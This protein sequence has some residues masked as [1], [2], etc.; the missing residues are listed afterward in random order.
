MCERAARS[1]H[2]EPCPTSPTYSSANITCM[3]VCADEYWRGRFSRLHLP[4]LYS[5]SP[6]GSFGADTERFV[7]CHVCLCVRARVC[8]CLYALCERVSGC[9]HYSCSFVC[10]FAGADGT[11][12]SAL[13]AESHQAQLISPDGNDDAA[14]AMIVDLL[15]ANS[16]LGGAIN[17][18][19]L[20]WP[21][22]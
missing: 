4:I 6:C 10:A 9:V 14:M 12:A 3:C 11:L 2:S 18:A 7:A 5:N 8:L 19:G 1:R 22:P 20:P 13:L 16:G 17:Y 15:E 21:L